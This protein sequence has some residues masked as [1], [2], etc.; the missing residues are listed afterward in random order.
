MATVGD[1]LIQVRLDRE[2]Q[3]QAVGDARRESRRII[4]ERRRPLAL[5]EIPER[6][7]E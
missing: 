6:G 3:R 4:E 1:L 2:Q 5:L 7:T